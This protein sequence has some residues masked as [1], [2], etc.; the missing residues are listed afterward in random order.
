[1]RKRN[2]L[3]KKRIPKV[4]QI[5]EGPN[6]RTGSESEIMPEPSSTSERGRRARDQRARESGPGSHHRLLLCSALVSSRLVSSGLSSRLSP[7]LG[8]RSRPAAPG[9]AAQGTSKQDIRC[10]PPAT[11][12]L[13]SWWNSHFRTEP[14]STRD[15]CSAQRRWLVPALCR[16]FL[17]REL[18][19]SPRPGTDKRRGEKKNRDETETE[20]RDETETRVLP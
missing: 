1:M 12:P 5:K 19:L 16:S 18:Q 13:P 15:L 7:Q 9:A 17:Q 8:G 14:N 11:A 10:T 2:I 20:R 3:L 4:D 6:S